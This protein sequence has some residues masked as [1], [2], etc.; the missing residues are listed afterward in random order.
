M[1]V[2][3]VEYGARNVESDLRRQEFGESRLHLV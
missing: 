3:A 1:L 2:E